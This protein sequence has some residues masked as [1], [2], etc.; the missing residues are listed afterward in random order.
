MTKDIVFLALHL[1]D[2]SKYLG[3]DMAGIAGTCGRPLLTIVDWT[4]N[5]KVG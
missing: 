2:H 3:V 5:T 4:V 1:P